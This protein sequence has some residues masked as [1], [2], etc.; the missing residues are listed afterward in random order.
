MK[1]KPQK[2]S[3]EST[4]QTE[5][6]NRSPI[7]RQTA[8]AF[9]SSLQCRRFWWFSSVK[10]PF[11]IR[12]RLRLFIS[13]QLSTVFLIQDGGS[14]NRWEYPLVPPKSACTAGYFISSRILIGVAWHVLATEDAFIFSLVASEINCLN[15]SKIK[16]Q[17]GQLEKMT[18][19]SK[20][21]SFTAFLCFQPEMYS[22]TWLLIRQP[23]VSTESICSLTY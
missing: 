20:A 6:S 1:K 12:W 5:K 13:P 23:F 11:W 10:S 18:T 16:Q 3:F 8:I 4:R 14:N 17:I 15:T 9:I 22:A 21:A 19:L 2:K 7:I